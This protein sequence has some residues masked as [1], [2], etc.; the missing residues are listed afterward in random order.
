MRES[1]LQRLTRRLESW[2]AAVAAYWRGEKV[3]DLWGGFVDR[4]FT[5]PWQRHNI[6]NTFSSTKT[7]TALSA[8][9]ADLEERGQRR[10]AADALGQYTRGQVH[11]VVVLELDAQILRQRQ[12]AHAGRVVG[13]ARI[14]GEFKGYGPAK[15]N[16]PDGLRPGC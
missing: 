11:Q 16:T 8:L 1:F 6:V 5:R 2:T 9:V 3:V 12:V 13:K 10:A 4:G 7:M 14:V 15:G